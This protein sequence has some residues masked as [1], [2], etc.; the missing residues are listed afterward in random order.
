[1]LRYGNT[2]KPLH[3]APSKF[4]TEL[5]RSEFNES[6]DLK[7]AGLVSHTITMKKVEETTA[8]ADGAMAALKAQ[9]A[10]YTE[11]KHANQ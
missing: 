6:Q 11:E 5:Y 8:G 3:I 1:M 7:F 10:S 4:R 2:S 9:M